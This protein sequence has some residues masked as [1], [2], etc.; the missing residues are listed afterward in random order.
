MWFFG[1]LFRL[2][3]SIFHHYLILQDDD[4][5]DVNNDYFIFFVRRNFKSKF[6]IQKKPTV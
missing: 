4:Y 2:N 6:H 5:D 1:D 3:L